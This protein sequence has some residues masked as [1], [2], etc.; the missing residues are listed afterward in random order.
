MGSLAALAA[1]IGEPFGERDEPR[2]PVLDARRGE[3]F[4]A[5]YGGTGEE[6]WPPFVAPPEELGGAGRPA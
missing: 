3:A 6:L 1:G 5:L 2:L 4:A